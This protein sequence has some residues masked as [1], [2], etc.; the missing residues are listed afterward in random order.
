MS[1]IGTLADIPTP[2]SNVCYWHKADIRFDCGHEEVQAL[3]NAVSVPLVNRRILA[4]V[5]AVRI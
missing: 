1:A 5:P 4:S 3:R 2:P